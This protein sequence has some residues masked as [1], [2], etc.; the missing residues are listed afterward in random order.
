MFCSKQLHTTF[1]SMGRGD[2][3]KFGCVHLRSVAA[4]IVS[5]PFLKD[6]L[7]CLFFILF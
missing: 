2:Q 5:E 1:G 6:Q 7:F 4:Q 3:I